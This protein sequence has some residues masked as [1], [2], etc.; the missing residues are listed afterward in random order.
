MKI[1]TFATLAAFSFGVQAQPLSQEPIE[2]IVSAEG[3]NTSLVKLGKKLW[4]DPRLSKSNT[5]SCNSC[6]N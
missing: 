6:H 1:M 3:L 4:F 5:I 2:V